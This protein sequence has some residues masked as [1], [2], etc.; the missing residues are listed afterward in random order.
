MTRTDGGVNFP[1]VLEPGRSC[2]AWIGHKELAQGLTDKNR[3][4]EFSLKEHQP[5]VTYAGKIKVRGMYLSASDKQYK[6]KKSVFDID[7]ALRSS[8]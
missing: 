1:L 7:G 2:A 5:D 8:D 6:S 4:I 3:R